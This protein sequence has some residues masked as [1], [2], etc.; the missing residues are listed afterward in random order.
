MPIAMI[1]LHDT[2]F[3]LPG[4]TLTA[5]LDADQYFLFPCLKFYPSLLK[6]SRSS[7]LMFRP[8]VMSIETES[9]KNPKRIRKQLLLISENQ[10]FPSP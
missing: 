7:I 8:C 4:C 1:L 3:A 2:H 10:H 9:R 6:C 5:P